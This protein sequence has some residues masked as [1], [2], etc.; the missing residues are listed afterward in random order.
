MSESEWIDLSR[1]LTNGMIHWPGD[2]PFRWER[3]ADLTGPGTANISEITANV[4]VGTHIDAPLH[5]ISGGQDVAELPLCK[6]CG[7][8][9]VVHLAEPRDV[10]IDDLEQADIEPGL[11][12]LLRTANEALWD[13]P[14]FNQ[15]YHGLSG[16]AAVWLVDHQV[17]LVGVDYLSVDRYHDPDKSAHY[18][19]L[20]N[21][22]IIVEGL[23][24]SQTHPGRYELV[25]LPLRI[26]GSDGSPAR[27]I[28]RPLRD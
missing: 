21:G 13:E 26:P 11:R 17:P 19:L 22:V 10:T 18:A 4:H 9:V 25:A 20:G 12:V 6:L 5:F 1:S 27:V 8:A 14:E 23:D 7:P 28:A 3:V 24:L 2:R 16:E 15:D